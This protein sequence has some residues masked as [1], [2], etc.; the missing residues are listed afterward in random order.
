MR[1]R[2]LAIWPDAGDWAVRFAALACVPVRVR[3]RLLERRGHRIAPDAR[4]HSG[5]IVFGAFLTVGPRAFINRNCEIQADVPVTVGDEVHLG[6][7]VRIVTTS[8][9]IGPS[10]RR[11]GERFSKPV[12]I[13]SGAWIG[14]GCQIMPGVTVGEG[15]VVAAGSVIIG[16]V[17]ANSLSGGVPA[18]T[19]RSLSE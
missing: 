18:R 17:P 16:D 14:A 11:A 3:R 10:R 5:T 6:P 15:A 12:T 19:I 9:D 7:G 4:I 2:L 8:H 1:R 13:G